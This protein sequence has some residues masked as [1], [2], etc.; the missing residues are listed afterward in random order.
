MPKIANEKI[1][2][3]LKEGIV[4]GDMKL[5]DGWLF[6]T[7]TGL[8]GTNYVQRALITAIG[9]GANPPAGCRLSHI[10]GSFHPEFVHRREEVRDAFQERRAST[11][12]WLLVANDVRQ[13]LLFRSKFD[14]PPKHQCQA[15]SQAQSDGSVDLYIQ[16]ESPGPDRESNWLPAP[17]DKF[18]LMMRLY[19]P[20]ETAPSIMMAHGKIPPVKAVE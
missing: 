5:E 6:T 19:W 20:K 1:M 16:N 10:G 11:R 7:R 2:L 8:Y 3:W 17:K 14:Q 4:A 9:L 13:G 12:K 18:I 15:G